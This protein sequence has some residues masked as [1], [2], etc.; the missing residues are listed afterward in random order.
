MQCKQNI[1]RNESMLKNT[2]MEMDVNR[3]F[4]NKRLTSSHGLPARIW[5]E[6][7]ITLAKFIEYVV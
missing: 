2:I 7:A 5:T 3:E 6:C 4:S 1:P